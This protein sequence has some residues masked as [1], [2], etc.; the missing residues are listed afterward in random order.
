MLNERKNRL[1]YILGI[2]IILLGIGIGTIPFLIK[3]NNKVI[4]KEKIDVFFETV[5]E[6]ENTTNIIEEVPETKKEK[7]QIEENYSMV[8]EIPKINLKKGLYDIKSKYNSVKYNIQIMKESKMPNIKNSNLILASHSGNS[9]IAFFDKLYKLQNGDK[10][11]VYYQNIKYIYEIVNIYEIEK[12][13]TALI[14]KD[15][16]ESIIALITCKKYTNNKQLVFIG[17]LIAK[18]NY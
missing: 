8:L 18:E 10:V 5:D 11:F 9:K 15:V 6:V 13:G 17:N 4:E 14:K 3:E 12:N 2:V 7:S 16:N 1:L